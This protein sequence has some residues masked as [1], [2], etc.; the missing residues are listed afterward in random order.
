MITKVILILPLY[1]ILF[2]IWYRFRHLIKITAD[3]ENILND[4][5]DTPKEDL[6]QQKKREELKS[7]IDKGKVHLLGHKWTHGR[8]DKAS[9]ETI[10]KTYAEYKQLELNEKDEKTTKT[11][12]KHAIN[13]YSTGISQWLKIKDVKKLRQGI[14]NDPVIKD[15]MANL[16]CLLLCTFGNLLA[17]VLVVVHA[18]NNLGLG[19]EPE[20][21]KKK[22]KKQKNYGGRL[23]LKTINKDVFFVKCTTCSKC[24]NCDKKIQGISVL[25]Y[26]EGYYVDDD[27]IIEWYDEE[28][29]QKRKVQKAQT[30]KELIPIAR[31]PLRWWDWCMTEDKKKKQKNYGSKYRPFCV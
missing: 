21:R 29:H 10:N 16:G 25:K 14:E 28:C 1:L 12:G 27:G 6:E 22:K 9:D 8:V 4:V 5:V 23:C 20:N 30:R 11:L 7:V 2:F 15:E 26:Y 17:H 13:L 3:V 19:N 18:M 31:H 24:T